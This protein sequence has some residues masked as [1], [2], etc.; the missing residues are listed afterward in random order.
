MV[1]KNVQPQ[2]YQLLDREA[3]VLFF[4]IAGE[5]IAYN[6][7]EYARGYGI[8]PY[9]YIRKYC[10]DACIVTGLQSDRI[11]KGKGS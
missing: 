11:K 9:D 2:T 6:N 8:I 3:E 7:T 10:L 5:L 1:T 4:A